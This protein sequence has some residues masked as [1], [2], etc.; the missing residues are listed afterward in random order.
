[1]PNPRQSRSRAMHPHL[2]RLWQAAKHLT[3]NKSTKLPTHQPKNLYKLDPHTP[4][5]IT[6]AKCK[7]IIQG[8]QVQKPSSQKLKSPSPIPAIP[9]GVA[10]G[11]LQD[12]KVC[13]S[14]KRWMPRAKDE[15]HHSQGPHI[16]LAERNW[17]SEGLQLGG[18]IEA[19]SFGTPQW[20][21]KLKVSGLQ[22]G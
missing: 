7:K 4:N 14:L 18:R 8:F 9:R 20:N 19:C 22:L 10:Q 21:F 16:H 13:F 2:I 5:I 12:V 17:S 3:P 1:M 15:K 6:T 11:L